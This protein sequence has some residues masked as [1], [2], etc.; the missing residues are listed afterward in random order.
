[1]DEQLN[2]QVSFT[3]ME[4][5][6]K[7]D[8]GVI[9]KENAKFNRGLPERVMQHLQLLRGDYGGFAVDRL[10][11][12]LQSATLAFRD[13]EDEEYVVCALIHDIGDMLA[14]HNHADMAATILK[15]FVSEANAWML[16]HHGMFQGY[17]FFHHLD[18]DRDM[19]ERFRGH[20]HFERTARFCAVH[21][22]NAFNSQYDTMPLEA[23]APMVQR[24]MARPKRSMY[25]RPKEGAAA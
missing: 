15:P 5:S 19:R 3:A 12:S 25:W 7:D 18:L 24:V 21:D 23:F 16:A 8:W 11:H 1:M 13:G 6:T 9:I 17:Y 22:Q 14:S 10:T 4:D 2:H 20:P